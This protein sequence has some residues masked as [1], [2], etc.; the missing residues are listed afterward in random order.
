MEA[1]ENAALAAC[2]AKGERPFYY[3]CDEKMKPTRSKRASFVLHV[4]EK[5]LTREKKP[6]LFLK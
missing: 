1:E 4:V 5:R 6:L 3:Y 2:T